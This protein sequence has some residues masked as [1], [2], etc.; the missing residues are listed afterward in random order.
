MLVVNFQT[1][2][3]DRSSRSPFALK[4]F[5]K[6][7]VPDIDIESEKGSVPDK[8]KLLAQAQ[9]F[10]VEVFRPGQILR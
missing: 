2:V 6:R 5:E 10:A 1:E 7:V 4:E 3:P 8:L 9:N